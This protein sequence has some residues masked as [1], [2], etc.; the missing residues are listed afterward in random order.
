MIFQD[1]TPKNFFSNNKNK[2]EIKCLDDSEVLSSDFS[3]L[4]SMDYQWKRKWLIDEIRLLRSLRQ[5]S[6]LRPLRSLRLQ[7]FIRP[8]KLLL[9]TSESSRHL[10]TALF[11]CFKNKFFWGSMMKF[12]IEFQHLFCKRLLRPAGVTFLKTV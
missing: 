12:C 3:G 10:N 7:R 5:L 11:L 2:T 4:K 9:R 6:L 8:R 1:S